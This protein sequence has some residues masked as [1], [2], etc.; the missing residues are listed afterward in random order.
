MAVSIVTMAEEVTAAVQWL[1]QVLP[2]AAREVEGVDLVLEA[3]EL[4]EDKVRLMQTVRQGLLESA[5]HVTLVDLLVAE[6]VTGGGGSQGGQGYTAGAGGGSSYCSP[7]A[8][9]LR[10]QQGGR[11]GNGI[12]SIAAASCAAGFILQNDACIALLSP[13]LQ[14]SL[15]PLN[16]FPIGKQN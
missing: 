10:N 5:Y 11:V 15:S 7:S 9:V 1:L 13:S 6:E 14:P 4:A 12:I 16:S 2:M 8:V 3:L